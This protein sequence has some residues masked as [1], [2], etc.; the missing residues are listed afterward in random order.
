MTLNEA[1]K[2]SLMAYTLRVCDLS[3]CFGEAR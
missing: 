3:Q 2:G 1:C